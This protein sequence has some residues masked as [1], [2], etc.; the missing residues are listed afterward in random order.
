MSR[1]AAY[2][3][4]E[5]LENVTQILDQE[6]IYVKDIT[7][8]DGEQSKANLEFVRT[9]HF[10]QRLY[11][12]GIRNQPKPHGKLVQFLS[13]DH[14]LYNQGLVLK[15]VNKL[16]KDCAENAYFRSVG[17]TKRKL[18]EFPSPDSGNL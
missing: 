16:L 11:D 3:Q 13:V 7:A 1:L 14:N 12:I 10:F 2:L 15:K 5:R 18:G 9:K 17:F 8:N 4:E 6:H